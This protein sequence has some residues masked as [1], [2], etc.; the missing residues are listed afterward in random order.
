MSNDREIQNIV[1]QLQN[2]QIRQATLVSRLE[3]LNRNKKN[4]RNTGDT[5]RP[6]EV[7]DWVRVL[8]PRPFQARRGKITKIG[9]RVT[10]LTAAGDPIVRA[11]QNLQRED[12]F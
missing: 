7:G 1:E 5:P 10:I 8:N 12:E 9:K 4:K 6:L 11:A 3:E 2:L